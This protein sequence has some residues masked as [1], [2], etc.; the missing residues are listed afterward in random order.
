M[1]SPYHIS[2]L[3]AWK[4]TITILHVYVFIFDSNSDDEATLPYH[5]VDPDDNVDAFDRLRNGVLN[6]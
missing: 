3:I 4:L 6:V 5:V 2:D 1:L